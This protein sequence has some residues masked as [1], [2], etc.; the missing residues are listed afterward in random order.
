MP[1]PMQHY[2]RRIGIVQRLSI[3][4][5]ALRQELQIERLFEN[6]ES[7]AVP[8]VMVLVLGNDAALSSVADAAIA[9]AKRVRFTEVTAR[10]LEPDVF[11]YR[12][13]AAEEVLTSYDGIVFVAAADASAARE[14]GRVGGAKELTNTVVAR[15]GGDAALSVALVDSGG[16][17]VSA[18]DDPSQEARPAQWVN[19]SRGS[20]LG[21]DIRSGTRPSTITIIPMIT[22]IMTTTMAMITAAIRRTT[23][24][25]I[26]ITL[27]RLT[28]STGLGSA[29]WA[30]VARMSKSVP[31]SA[32]SSVLIELTRQTGAFLS[33]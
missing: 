29:G 24:I 18:P 3:L 8:S 14:L 32:N 15:A 13:L 10:A 5:Q 27:R 26:S 30:S 17:V 2:A 12:S 7:C 6:W 33:L 19:A 21:F 25:I 20:R 4:G 1:T 9:G 11:R 28:R 31:L 16:I 22:R 23:T